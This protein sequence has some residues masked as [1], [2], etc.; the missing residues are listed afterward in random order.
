MIDFEEGDAVGLPCQRLVEQQDRGLDAGVRVEHAGRQRDHGDEVVLYQHLAQLPVGGLTLEDDTLGHDDAGAAAGREVLGHVVHEQHFAAL[1]LHRKAV[2]RL[3]AALRRHE[4]RVG[5]DHVGVLVPALLA[6]E[7]VVL[8]DVR[9]GEAVQIH[10]DARQAH[11]VGR[12]VVALE[13]SSQPPALVGGERAV[14]VFV[15]IGFEDVLV[16]R[17]QKAGGAAGGVEHGVGLLRVHDL[18][19]EIDDVARRAELAG[20]ALAAQHREQVFEGVAQAL[21][22]VVLELV[23]DLQERAQ[24]LRVAIRQE[25]VLED[26]AEERRDAGVLRHLGDGLG[27]EVQG[28]VATQP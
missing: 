26:L 16:R 23:D 8:V 28:F 13:V 4:G 24:G 20:V 27:V 11:H 2:V 12:D 9:V 21:G 3:D 10:V 14:A 7:R 19:D 5:E 17:D 6:G 15:G 22:V 18:D 1:A 25:G